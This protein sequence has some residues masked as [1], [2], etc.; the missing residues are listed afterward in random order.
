MNP[1]IE[2][3]ALRYKTSSNR[4]EFDDA[5]LQDFVHEILAEA[6]S[7]MESSVVYSKISIKKEFGIPLEKIL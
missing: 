1:R 5:R 2:K 7:I 3:H 4:Y 6:L